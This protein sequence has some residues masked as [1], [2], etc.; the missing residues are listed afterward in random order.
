MTQRERLDK[1]NNR[2]RQLLAEQLH[3]RK[4]LVQ[5]KS[6][7]Q[8]VAVV[9]ACDPPAPNSLEQQLHEHLGKAL[10]DY[11]LPSQWYFVDALPRNANGKLDRRALTRQI[12]AQTDSH[13][14]SN[15]PTNRSASVEEP[16]SEADADAH[17][18]E[19]ILSAIWAEVL[20][21]D[22][23]QLDDDYFELGGD[24]IASMQ[25]VARA[26]KQDL[27]FSTQDIM[28]FPSVRQLTQRLIALRSN[29]TDE[30]RSPDQQ[31]TES[32]ADVMRVLNLGDQ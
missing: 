12:S 7:S 17:S 25:I 26:G 27:E 28:R 32:V 23:V 31:D 2:Q 1:L 19:I 20:F 3:A 18:I 30:L 6:R 13:S 8:L 16:S 22:D 5:K 4:V 29:K 21:M 15:T 9:Q 24:S 10:P 14:N 11:M